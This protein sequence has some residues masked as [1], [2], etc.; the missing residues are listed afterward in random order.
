MSN[1]NEWTELSK[2]VV[3]K[4]QPSGLWTLAIEWLNGPAILK[5]EADNSDWY[6]SEPDTSK[7][8]ADGHLT[9]LLSCKGC[10][11][12]SAPVGALIGKVGG[13]SASAT[14]GT[15]F[16]VGKFALLEIDKSKGPLYLTINDEATGFGNNRGEIKVT[17]SARPA[18]PPPAV[19]A[20]TK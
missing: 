10:L 16:A 5:L 3:V 1:A 13:S 20:A 9:S 2:G 4:A 14:D 11:L 15:L 8:N 12:P 17:I 6:Y 19:A 7:T 18:P